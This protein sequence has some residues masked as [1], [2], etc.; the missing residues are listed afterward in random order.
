MQ[1][2]EEKQRM[3]DE[4][5]TGSPTQIGKRLGLGSS[6]NARTREK[7][8]ADETKEK[9]RV[10][11]ARDGNRHEVILNE[12]ENAIRFGLFALTIMYF[13]AIYYLR[14]KLDVKALSEAAAAGVGGVAAVAQGASVEMNEERMNAAAEERN[15]RIRKKKVGNKRKSAQLPYSPIYPTIHPIIIHHTIIITYHRSTASWRAP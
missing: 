4:T 12:T 1:E 15:Q 2:E 10:K 7:E 3:Q 13:R 11:V 8:K 9:G 6:P 14:K 5:P